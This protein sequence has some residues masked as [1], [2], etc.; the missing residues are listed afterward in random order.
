MGTYVRHYFS[1]QPAFINRLYSKNCWFNCLFKPESP[2]RTFLGK[3]E[4]PMNWLGLEAKSVRLHKADTIS[5]LR[6]MVLLLKYVT[7]IL[8]NKS[9]HG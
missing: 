8:L 5:H 4:Q 2:I 6:A 9:I 1:F 3:P 7:N